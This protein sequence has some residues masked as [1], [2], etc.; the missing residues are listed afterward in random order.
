ML[1]VDVVD[2]FVMVVG[3][4]T[5]FIDYITVLTTSDAP[6]LWVVVIVV[7]W[8]VESVL[9]ECAD[10]QYLSTLMPTHLPCG[11]WSGWDVVIV[12]VV[13]F[14]NVDEVIVVVVVV[15]V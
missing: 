12:F 14:V 9:T 1:G 11:C 3:V 7:G 10:I 5:A 13:V 6:G 4:E 2:V 8:V 15:C